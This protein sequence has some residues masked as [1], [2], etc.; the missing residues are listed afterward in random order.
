MTADALIRALPGVE[1]FLQLEG[2]WN[3]E[4]LLTIADQ[5]GRL[6]GPE[7]HAAWQRRLERPEPA[8]RFTL[9]A[10]AS[11]WLEYDDDV[12]LVVYETGLSL[13][14]QNVCYAE[15]QVNPAHFTERRWSLDRLLEAL[16]DGRRRVEVAWKVKLRW[17]L[18]V[19]R[20]QPRHADDAVRLAG[21]E[22]GRQAGV[23]GICLG[24]PEGAQPPGQF[25]R[26]FRAAARKGI[27]TALHANGLKGDAASLREELELLQPQRL[28]GGLSVADDQELLA[29]LAQQ[30]L[31]VVFT[32]S[33]ALSLGL[34][35]SREAYPLRRLADAGLRLMPSSSM[36]AIYGASHAEERLAAVERCGLAVDE[37]QRMILNAAEACWLPDDEKDALRALLLERMDAA[38]AEQ[39]VSDD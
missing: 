35:D 10:E 27:P 32:M 6:D 23:V 1:L 5:N 3:T 39:P 9:M 37:L 12:A 26:A 20:D 29:S 18:S 25:E 13:A 31:P 7:A 34:V 28:I 36:P 8:E 2:D 30:Q 19:F 16:N 33:E 38:L 24:G 15:L 21:S 14:R 22:A 4:R 17:V 11:R